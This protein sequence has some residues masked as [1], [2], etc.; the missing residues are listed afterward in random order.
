MEIYKTPKL[1]AT[2]SK[3]DLKTWEGEA[4]P[5]NNGAI[6][7]FTFGLETGKKQTQKKVITEGKNIG[8]SNE[9][10]PFEQAKKEIISKMNKKIDSG[11][12]TDKTNVSTPILPMLAHP[13]NKRKHNIT[14]PAFAQPK[15]DGIRMIAHYDNEI[16][17]FSR[18]GKPF[19]KMPHIE[20]ELEFYFKRLQP[21]IIALAAT[22]YKGSLKNIYI[23][24]ELYSDTLKFE[25]LAGAVRRSDC[26]E[27]ILKQIK[28]HVFDMFSLDNHETPFKDRV[29]II[30]GGKEY[31]RVLYNELN[32]IK[33]VRTFIVDSEKDFR[34]FNSSYCIPN[35]YEGAMIR[36]SNGI[37]KLGHRSADLQKLKEFQD[38]EYKIIG[39][40]EGT[41]TEKGCVIWECSVNKSL[42][43][44]VRP[45]GSKAER[46]GYFQN[47]KEHIGSMLTV[48]FQ[49]LTNDGIPRFPV[50]ISIRDYE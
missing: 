34:D 36:N 33:P 30:Y 50:G 17:T 25:E 27:E 39:F 8:R 40:K 18:K 29:H 35:G 28:Y 20:K 31:N 15:I 38:A 44:S 14:Y 41:G 42:T 5:G 13:F 2:S 9:T 19:T 48:R 37:Y 6:M 12:T 16:T 47:G 23:D 3:G 32:Y 22:P 7:S 45:R 4:Y 46:Q 49:E 26:N 10:T 21:T 11:Y 43:F 1:Y 24:G